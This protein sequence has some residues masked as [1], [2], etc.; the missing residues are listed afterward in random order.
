MY[1]LHEIPVRVPNAVFHRSHQAQN[2]ELEKDRNFIN[3][4]TL[5]HNALSLN[6]LLS[7]MR[8]FL[9]PFEPGK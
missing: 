6:K 2:K 5:E 9:G 7:T 1:L 3:L 8:V 4:C